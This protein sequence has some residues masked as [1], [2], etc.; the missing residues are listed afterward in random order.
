MTRDE[1]ATVLLRPRYRVQET[2]WTGSYE[3]HQHDLILPGVFSDLLEAYAFRET[4]KKVPDR[5]LYKVIVVFPG[6]EGYETF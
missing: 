5:R 2:R 6:D 4:C 3:E 1:Y